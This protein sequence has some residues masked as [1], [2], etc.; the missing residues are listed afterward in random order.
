MLSGRLAADLVSSRLVTR[1]A[2][3]PL[4]RRVIWSWTSK[5][6]FGTAS[7][8]SDH[9]TWLRAVSVRLTDTRR[10]SEAWRTLPS[11]T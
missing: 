1:T 9:N 10:L 6:S 8:F 7:Y 2:K 11:T 5:I 4:M 3:A